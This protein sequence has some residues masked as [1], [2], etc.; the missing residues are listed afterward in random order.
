MT[1][2]CPIESAL[3]A[4]C[5]SLVSKVCVLGQ[6]QPK[7]FMV[8]EIRENVEQT[9]AQRGVL[10]ALKSVNAA[11]VA[12]SRIPAPNVIW[13]RENALPTSAKGNV[14]RK[15]AEAQYKDVMQPAKRAPAHHVDVE[16]LVKRHLGSMDLALDEPL[17]QAGLDSV[18]VADVLEEMRAVTGM[19]LPS[20][21]VFDHPTLRQLADAL[22]LAPAHAG[23][24]AASILSPPAGGEALRP[25][26]DGLRCALPG[27]VV[28]VQGVGHSADSAW[29]SVS[30]VPT[31]RWDAL[32]VPVGIEASVANRTRHGAFVESAELF[33]NGHFAI[34][35]AEAGA[36]DPQQRLTLETGYTT[37][38]ASG[39]D[40]A[41]L[42]GSGVGVALGIYALDFGE[43]M[44]RNGLNRSVYAMTGLSLSI[45]SGR[46]SFA[47]G[48][49]GPCASFD[50]ACSASL[51]AF[52]S[53]V[54]ALQS[55]ECEAHLVAGVNL[56]LAQSS[57]INTAIAGM[58]S[59]AGR[60]HTF[61]SRAD[62]FARG[63]G[64]GGAS[65]SRSTAP[66]SSYGSAVRQDGR[67]ASITAPNGQ[68]QQGLLC[69]ALAAGCVAA[70]T[71]ALSEAHGTGTSLGDPVETGA[72]AAALHWDGGRV[73]ALSGAKGNF[74][75]GESTAGTTGLLLLASELCAYR[76]SPNA[77]LRVLNP[78][79]LLSLTSGHHMAPTQSAAAAVS[80]MPVASTG[81]VSSFGFSGT[82]AHV[83]L[84]SSPEHATARSSVANCTPRFQRR[85]F[86]WLA[87]LVEGG[88]ASTAIHA[89][90]HTYAACW[91]PAPPVDV[92]ASGSRLLLAGAP[93]VALSRL[94]AAPVLPAAWQVVAVLLGGGES[95]AP[96]LDGV[97]LTCALSQQLVGLAKP[98]RVV[99]L[100]YGT[101]AAAG[102]HAASSAAHGGAWGLAR[103]VRLEHAA[104]RAQSVDVSRGAVAVPW[105]ACLA[106]TME[107]E[108]A[109]SGETRCAARLRA[110][111]ASSMR[112]EG[113]PRGAYAITGGL[114]GLGLRAAT[115]LVEGGA[116]H[117][118]LASR[119]GLVV[120]GG[121]G[122][123]AGL[124]SLTG[125]ARVVACDSAELRD[126]S[127]LLGVG[128]PTGVL[129]AAGVLRDKMLRAM[130]GEHLDAVRAPKA[131][132]AS[133]LLTAFAR[134]PLEAMA[135]FSSVAST[136]GKVGQ[137]NYAAAN[138]YLDS[139][140]WSRRLGGTCGTC[141]QI[142]A[143]HG[144]GMSAAAFDHE[145]LGA[146]GI[147]LD[148]FEAWLAHSLTPFGRGELT[149]ALLPA[150]L[151]TMMSSASALA[152]A[153]SGAGGA[154]ACGEEA[155]LMEQGCMLPRSTG[156]YV[157][158][159]VAD[160]VALLE[161]NDASHYNA[162][163]IEMAADLLSAAEWL[164]SQPRDSIKS[165][166]LQGHGDHFCPG[167]NMYRM[168]DQSSSLT[169]VARAAID[170]F[171][172][173]CRL[174]TLPVP[175]LCAAHGKVLGGGLA[176]CLLTD[177]VASDHEATFQVGERSRGI[178]PAGLLRR[179][180]ADAIGSDAA[181]GLYVVDAELT[182]T[183]A[184]EKGI[185]Q[186]VASSVRSTQQL[187]QNLALSYSSTRPVSGQGRALSAELRVL[188]GALP[189]AERCILA[190]DAFAQA[191]SLQAQATEPTVGHP[192]HPVFASS[193]HTLSRGNLRQRAQ[194]A[195]AAHARVASQRAPQWR[196][197]R[198]APEE[199]P[200]SADGAL[201]QQLQLL[202][203]AQEA[204]RISSR[205]DT[206]AVAEVEPH[207]KPRHRV[208]LTRTAS[209]L[210]SRLIEH[211]GDC[212]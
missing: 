156:Q 114:G 115:L 138:S 165:A 160:H 141:L 12:Y 161:L 74:A 153:H 40:R 46:L 6:G 86:R 154:P 50:T 64:A 143:V 84:A 60:C 61:D 206:A 100:T 48:L 131:M 155:L 23:V 122:L 31:T 9:A 144:A 91:A 151:L 4:I 133:R 127:A 96:S 27:R 68:A 162:L 25:G 17:M 47:L 89:Q 126:A 1:N 192:P 198:Y 82:I 52:H 191:R 110:C 181:M 210:T 142:P 18:G 135:C 203:Q 129:H 76:A 92:A 77:Q 95:A 109:W 45:A 209:E 212:L 102:T 70:G 148:E 57:S 195:L 11:Q 16:G 83:V 158:L 88:I 190:V 58:T 26:V 97:R 10:E 107:A 197:V 19:P 44:E 200:A 183:Q 99:V 187:A 174:R 147:T 35:P 65:L 53:A 124:L 159:Q 62:G 85:A 150:G 41:A 51:V 208:E 173:F 188:S 172:G 186:M 164:A 49:H 21:L 75:H 194:A 8:V 67:S 171:D 207:G 128:L 123:E 28:S 170:F 199:P 137:A 66:L 118:L 196:E 80:E 22:R 14:I 163:S 55:A 175:V 134:T 30:M 37:L 201:T 179:A 204:P 39:R 81:G 32:H 79:V 176:A 136:F 185:V 139:F 69:A 119:S 120:R 106:S 178:Y 15:K 90:T 108:A 111:A 2:P 117:V 43:A 13:A 24:P 56:T 130:A 105:G 7:P 63:E 167:G 98:P 149:Q 29:D 94:A 113:L 202:E 152:D 211:P 189:L 182:C 101:L 103:V 73:L 132:A 205:E 87:T 157:R 93:P 20:S 36:M 59:V 177:F 54:R 145:Q 3:L 72:L 168:R 112:R 146:M 116:T 42:S 71:H 125:A 38:Y 33:D 169:A 193:G 34:S 78:H 104:L 121:Q 184:H 5:D 180:L 140:S 166:V